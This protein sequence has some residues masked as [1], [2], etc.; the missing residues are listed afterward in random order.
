MTLK[1]QLMLSHQT[2]IPISAYCAENRQQ[3]V[4]KPSLCPA[5]CG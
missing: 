3:P 2:C 5:N 1:R 4:A